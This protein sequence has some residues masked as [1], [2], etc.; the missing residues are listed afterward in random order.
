[1]QVTFELVRPNDDDELRRLRNCLYSFIEA[2]DLVPHWKEWERSNDTAPSYVQKAM[3]GGVC[4]SGHYVKANDFSEA[5]MTLLS[6]DMEALHKEL[7]S[8]TKRKRKIA[9]SSVV[10]VLNAILFAFFPKCAV[11][12]M[13][14]ASFFS[15]MGIQ[16]VQYHWWFKPLLAITLFLNL[17]FLLYRAKQRNGYAP[18]ILGVAGCLQLLLFAYFWSSH[19]LLIAGFLLLLVASIYNSLPK[20][21]I[22]YIKNKVKSITHRAPLLQ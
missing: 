17:G 9:F 15:S 20:Y 18:F 11:C 1:M 12:W 4:L 19:F 13:V 21:Y 8:G 10:P 22:A 5:G 6:N 7:A 2:K 16:L 3:G 14:Y